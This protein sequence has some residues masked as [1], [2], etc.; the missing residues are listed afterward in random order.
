MTLEILSTLFFS[1]KIKIKV[2]IPYFFKIKRKKS[3]FFQK[4]IFKNQAQKIHGIFTSSDPYYYPHYSYHGN[5]HLRNQV[6]P[7]FSPQNWDPRE[8]TIIHHVSKVDNN[9][10]NPFW[11][12]W[13]EDRARMAI[14]RKKRKGVAVM[15][16]VVDVLETCYVDACAC[17][18]RMDFLL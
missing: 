18:M 3:F 15:G 5:N 12:S 14:H 9:P 13:R 1:K 2:E 7:D 10:D 11:A 8:V 16:A 6:H 4:K 17:T